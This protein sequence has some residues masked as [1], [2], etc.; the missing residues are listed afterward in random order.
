MKKVILWI[1]PQMT[2][3][4]IFLNEIEDSGPTFINLQPRSGFVTKQTQIQSQKESETI[5]LI[6]Q[7]NNSSLLEN[8]VFENERSEITH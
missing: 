6:N 2:L 1:A 4:K 5:H 3:M 7:M 8:T